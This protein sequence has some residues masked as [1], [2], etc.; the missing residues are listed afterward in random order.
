[1][2]FVWIY[3][4]RFS[5]WDM[6]G[7][8]NELDYSI[9]SV[10]KNYQGDVRCFVV[11]D[12]PTPMLDV[13]HIQ[14]PEV[15]ME[16]IVHGQPQHFDLNNKF[17]T[18][19]ESEINEEFVLMYDDIFI[20]K[21]TSKE[22]IMKTYG[23]CELTDLA[24]HAKKRSGGRP[25]KKLWLDTYTYIFTYRHSKGLKTYEWETHLPRFMEK[26]K[27]KWIFDRL[28]VEN[29]PRIH[30]SLYSAGCYVDAENKDGSKM[31]PDCEI[32]ETHIMPGGFQSDIY[33]HTPGMDFDAEF[34]CHHMNIG[35]NVIVPE[36]IE[37]MH[38][39]F[40]E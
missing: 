35:D 12:I 2:D 27:L 21:P 40:G 1:M 15:I 16:D 13:I 20:L 26:K 8:F 14:A 39:E 5:S 6:S 29:I 22:E 4:K 31:F 28:N 7:L 30:T 32:P 38:R 37:R 36:L 33:A 11:G 9:R 34:N 10:R 18:I 23:K 19:L 25:F 3:A 17:T 24:A